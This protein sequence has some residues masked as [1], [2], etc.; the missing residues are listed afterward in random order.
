AASQPRT[1][2][3]P[4]APTVHNLLDNARGH[5]IISLL[6]GRFH[7]RT[8]GESGPGVYTCSNKAVDNARAPAWPQTREPGRWAWEPSRR[9]LRHEPQKHNDQERH[10]TRIVRRD[11]V[12]AWDTYRKH[13]GGERCRESG[14]GCSVARSWGWCVVGGAGRQSGPRRPSV[15]PLPQ[16]RSRSPRRGSIV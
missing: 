13:A 3:P 2:A 9:H 4:L 14:A 7:R 10:H 15:R 12:R 8:W 11:I 1:A 5:G 6:L 16:P